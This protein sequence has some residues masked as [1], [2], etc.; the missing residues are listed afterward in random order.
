MRNKDKD[1]ENQTEFLFSAAL[2]LCEDWELA[3]ELT[4]DTLLSALLALRGGEEIADLRG[5]LLTVLRR[6]H[7]DWLRKKYRQPL[8]LVGADFDCPD[9][10]DCFDGIAAEEEAEA[11]RREV[12]YLSEI[13]RSIT[14][15]HYF[16]G[17][18]VETIAAELGIPSGTVKSRLAGA[19]NE[20][21]KGLNKMQSYTA[22]S[23]IPQ[24]L[25][26]RNSGQCGM[27]GEP[28]SLVRDDDLLTQNLLLHAYEAPVTV[29][30]LSRAIGVPAVY[31]EPV[32]E[33]LVAEEL[34]KQNGARVYTDFVIYEPKDWVRYISDQKQFATANAEAYCDAVEKAAAALKEAGIANERLKRYLM[35]SV[36]DKGLFDT[37]LPYVRPQVFPDRPNGGKWIAFGSQYP[38]D[39][40]ADERTEY[41]LAG[42]RG[43]QI[44][45]YLG[46]KDLLLLNYETALSPEGKYD[47]FGYENYGE[48][49]ADLLR[50]FYLIHKGISPDSVGFTPK[51]LKNMPLM[52]RRGMVQIENGMPSLLVPCLT[53]GQYEEFKKIRDAAV[54]ALAAVL[55]E[56]MGR[57]I[58]AR[59][60]KIPAHL[61]SVPDQKLCMPYMPSPMMFVYEAI[62][63][64]VQRRDLGYPCPETVVVID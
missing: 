32:I 13:Y 38:E 42:E 44:E 64:G 31:I 22:N 62:E 53:H 8:I 33:R 18:S 7:C 47:G 41:N 45:E 46:S 14:V 19:R 55:T 37:L 23:S 20:I 43:V 35:I 25:Y 49:E 51:M 58:A 52:E 21:R 10:T 50:L 1:L 24:K 61:K 39:T 63:R 40:D 16:C 54:N 60:K 36:A 6:R 34:M 9:E 12:A 26:V 56:P 27:D 59:K 17:E 48:M 28:M 30:E 2:R 5:W 4:Q 11:V 3:G 57:F 15:R 29:T